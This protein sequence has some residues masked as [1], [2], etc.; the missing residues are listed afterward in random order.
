MNSA[1]VQVQSGRLG[2]M[3][4]ARTRQTVCGANTNADTNINTS[5]STSTDRLRSCAPHCALCTVQIAVFSAQ[6]RVH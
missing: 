2:K 1:G 5:T 6:S 3:T 4:P